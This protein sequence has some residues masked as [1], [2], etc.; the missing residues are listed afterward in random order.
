MK[1][2]LAR[3]APLEVPAG[4]ARILLSRA[5]FADVEVSLDGAR[6][7]VVAVV[8]ADGRVSAGGREVRVGYVGREAFEMERCRGARWCAAGAPLPALAG[9]VEAIAAAPRPDGRRPVAWQIR[10]ERDR[11]SV[12]EDAAGRDGGRAPRGVVALVRD[13]AR[14]RIAAPE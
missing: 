10:V 7:R 11:A 4:D 14:W 2:A 3:A 5:T 13:G 9:V 6:A 12:G 1:E 8:D